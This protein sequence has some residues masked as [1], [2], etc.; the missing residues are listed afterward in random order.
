MGGRQRDAGCWEVQGGKGRHVPWGSMRGAGMLGSLQA[1]EAREQS[2]VSSRVEGPAHSLSLSALH[3]HSRCKDTALYLITDSSGRDAAWACL[4]LKPRD[5][6]SR[7]THGMA[8]S[9]HQ[10]GSWETPAA[11]HA[12]P[13]VQSHPRRQARLLAASPG[14]HLAGLGSALPEQLTSNLVLSTTIS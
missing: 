9:N 8:A 13:R 11:G 10:P 7:P 3:G 6:I 4:L 14:S 12:V 5:D 2:Q 1:W